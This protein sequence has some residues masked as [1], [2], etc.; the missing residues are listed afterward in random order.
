MSATPVINSPQVWVRYL[1]YLPPSPRGSARP[2][3][4]GVPG[5]PGEG[6]GQVCP[7]AVGV[8]NACVFSIPFWCGVIAW[9][10]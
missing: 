4:Q 7:L 10:V 8:V 2:F 3:P 6:S 1:S 9:L 5:L